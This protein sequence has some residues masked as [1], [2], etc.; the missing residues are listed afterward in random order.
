MSFPLEA[1]PQQYGILFSTMHK[2]A[3][4]YVYAGRLNDAT[5]LLSSFADI[6]THDD[7]SDRMQVEML[8]E[9]ANWETYRVAME[10]GAYEG[11]LQAIKKAQSLMMSKIQ[12][13]RV[14]DLSGNIEYFIAQNSAERDFTKAQ[15]LFHAS[16]I[17]LAEADSPNELCWAVFHVG[18]T[19]Q[20]SDEADDAR[21]HFQRA[22]KLARTHNLALESSYIMRHLGFL[23]Q[24]EEKYE[25]ALEA[26][27]ES[28]AIRE[29][30]GFKLFLPLSY[31]AV[32]RVYQQME[33]KH[34]ALKYYE[35]AVKQARKFGITRQ[36]MLVLLSY[37]SML[38]DLNR[39]DD[40]LKILKEAQ[41]YAKAIEHQQALRMIQEKLDA[42]Q[43][44][45]RAS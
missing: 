43:N 16:I 41:P 19:H 24:A 42:I 37:S 38:E 23:L 22:E 30:L 20:Y 21:A 35:E 44:T 9:Y 6:A 18:L 13:G 10:G 8:L 17:T 26:L 29:K 27:K 1:V 40:V 25:D 3:T 28:L 2:I 34:D 11:A 5:K 15:A 4:A 45:E 31:M 39:K 12:R 14:L 36:L 32:A 7:V 33:Q